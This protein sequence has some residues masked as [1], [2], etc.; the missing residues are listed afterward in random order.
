MKKRFQILAL[1]IERNTYQ[2]VMKQLRGSP[3]V[4]TCEEDYEL[5]ANSRTD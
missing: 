1:V 4:L 5:E 2:V 3:E